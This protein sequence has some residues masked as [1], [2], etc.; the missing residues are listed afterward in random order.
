MVGK[1]QDDLCSVLGIDFVYHNQLNSDEQ[2]M[3]DMSPVLEGAVLVDLAGLQEV[4]PNAD[5]QMIVCKAML[6]EVLALAF[7]QILV[8]A[9]LNPGLR[10]VGELQMK[11]KAVMLESTASLGRDLQ[12]CSVA[13]EAVQL[14]GVAN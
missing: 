13:E 7:L 12:M 1:K 6:V 14:Q 5:L 3:V 8:A 2:E 11:V 4:T 10:I 9:L